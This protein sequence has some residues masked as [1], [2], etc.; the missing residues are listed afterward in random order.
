M[1]DNGGGRYGSSG[2][3]QEP[4][5]QPGSWFTPT[6]DRYRTQSHYQD[7]YEG[8]STGEGTAG[9]AAPAPDHEHG[10]GSFVGFPNTG[11]YP[12]MS[13]ARPG[14]AE[15][16]P[17]ALGGLGTE[18]GEPAA[19]HPAPGGP[20]A[21]PRPGNDLTGSLPR[22]PGTPSYPGVP[23]HSG[24]TGGPSPVGGT[25]P[26][27]GPTSTV[28]TPATGAQ[29][30]LRGAAPTGG[31]QPPAQYDLGTGS[32][33]AYDHRAGLPPYASGA[34]APGAPGV[35][36]VPNPFA[37]PRTADPMPSDAPS[38]AD[39]TGEAPERPA[40]PSTG[41]P[42][43]PAQSEAGGAEENRA[44][45]VYRVPT[46]AQPSWTPQG[47]LSGLPLN[48]SG[49][50]PGFGS[51]VRRDAAQ[52]ADPVAPADDGVSA[53]GSPATRDESG[54][55]QAAAGT[56]PGH[57][58]G[59]APDGYPAGGSPNLPQPEPDRPHHT[60]APAFG[61]PTP[62]SETGWGADPHHPIGT[63]PAA[64][65]AP[66]D[67]STPSERTTHSGRP[68]YRD[69]ADAAPYGPPQG[70]G[71]GDAAPQGVPSLPGT[72]PQSSPP[73]THDEPVRPTYGEPFGTPQAAP[74]GGYPSL[75]PDAAT[76]TGGYPSLTSDLAA[77][78]GG[79]PSL[80]PDPA[81]PGAPGHPGAHPDDQRGDGHRDTRW[82]DPLATGG[83]W[84][85]PGHY[86]ARPGGGD[87]PAE[88]ADARPSDDAYADELS[89]PYLGRPAAEEP[90]PGSTTGQW[91]SPWAASDVPPPTT[92][93]FAGIDP[94][95]PAPGA[96][97]PLSSGEETTTGGL[98]AEPARPAAEP[99][100]DLGTG[101]GNTW[102][103]SRDD[104]RLPDSVRETALQAEQKRR[105]GSPDH[106]TQFFGAAPGTGP[107][108]EE[109]PAPEGIPAADDPLA[110]I[111]AQ[112]AQARAQE[113][114]APEATGGLP[115]EDW[116]ARLSPMTS[117]QRAVEDELG[118]D[119]R[120]EAEHDHW[121]DPAA[122]GPEAEV[123][124]G[125][126]AEPW[127]PQ[128]DPH[129]A[130]PDSWSPQQP[131]PEG[132]APQPGADT[133]GP[134]P[135][136]NWAQKT[137]YADAM[138]GTQAMPALP[139]GFV[140]DG[141]G[142]GYPD[143]GATGFPV[144]HGY[145]GGPD[146]R[147]GYGEGHA[148]DGRGERYGDRYDGS[149]D[150]G[151]D[152]RYDHG[153]DGGPYQGYGAEADRYGDQGY[154][155]YEGSDAYDDTYEDRPGADGEDRRGGRGRGGRDPITDDFPGFDEHP[156]GAVADPYPGYDNIDY[157]PETAPGATTTLWLG[158]V[159]L[160]PVIGLFTAIAAFVTGSKAKRDIQ[161]SEGELEGLNLVKTGTI[162]AAAG[163]A[164]FVVEAV[165]VVLTLL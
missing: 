99:G 36:G 109:P 104:P 142:E 39:R 135:S 37:A 31:Q 61:A 25:E 15:P 93:P 102:A 18:P 2:E 124:Q 139:D 94:A 8:E 158:I 107:A 92:G 62:T 106:T 123:P 118:P 90:A 26:A 38:G 121:A 127:V 51:S 57:T 113:A 98:P 27:D 159:G 154:D 34:A 65:S 89:R 17:S 155:A 43:R 97:D 111:A 147:Y 75:A 83:S 140:P 131:G 7:P 20:Q 73:P 3:E 129:H 133:G 53:L 13:A 28:G 14:M 125:Y 4:R 112:Q 46:G 63:P 136:H 162:L 49:G 50:Y 164:L 100:G 91:E 82:E 149:Y 153:P 70:T 11:G 29:P 95:A 138:E 67:F 110:A 128:H 156:P 115:L 33:P 6:G 40:P 132:L 78:T 74:T 64:P 79:Y 68:E 24:A 105:D 76:H 69:H 137:S 45:G 44:G 101:S 96:A 81:V 84:E 87:R 22:L 41:P 19:P 48:V 120:G 116:G 163:I 88:P 130:G 152:E 66:A 126:A 59:G 148:A 150:E 10:T 143:H 157:W 23:G 52:P 58:W 141:R 134:A 16:Y 32:S 56:E 42:A 55:E 54:P 122:R 117:P 151:Y 161:A 77:P 114:A 165:V 144:E 85:R 72:G 108:S 160:V 71:Y 119:G 21:A 30:S 1:T 9:D 5:Q 146:D 35:P 80:A 145:D 47:E 60:A 12:G 103:F 86:D